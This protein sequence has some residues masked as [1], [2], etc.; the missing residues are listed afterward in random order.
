MNERVAIRA[1]LSALLAFCGLRAFAQ[2]EAPADSP[3]AGIP[4]T[5][6]LVISKCGTCHA[7]DEKGNL[8]RIS[9]ER[10][11]PEGWQ[12]AI[13]R[14][15]RL[16]GVKLTESDSR[17]IVKY[18][19]TYHGLAP[20][21]AKPVMF[22][23]E[24]RAVDENEAPAELKGVCNYCHAYSRALSWRRPKS[25]WLLLE[26]MH[27]GMFITAEMT[28][29]RSFFIGPRPSTPNAPEPGEAAAE[30]LAKTAPLHTPEWSAW[31]ARLTAPRLAGKWLVVASVPGRGKY[32]GELNV[33][34]GPSEDE[35]KTTARLKSALDN[36]VVTRT[37]QSIV[38]AGYA[39]RGRSKGSVGANAPV[40]DLNR[41]ARETLWIS[42]DQNTAEGRWYWGDYQ[43]FGYDVKLVRASSEPTI[44]GVNLSALKTGSRGALVRLFV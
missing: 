1:V 19:A 43:E 18:L 12:E 15:V 42:P 34:Q 39:W 41:E 8:S 25:E 30:Y 37:G 7:R 22:L 38:Y 2:S 9:W 4:V 20:E 35:F 40:D 14:M 26:Q 29:R 36:S 31:R 23:A 17:A 28:F 33:Q 24:H 27:M 5:N 44:Y 21:E 10:T 13:K 11:T 6:Q 3:E 16:N 32:Y